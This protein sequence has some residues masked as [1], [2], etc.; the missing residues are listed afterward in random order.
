MIKR[1][2]IAVFESRAVNLT[3]TISSLTYFNPLTKGY[4]PVDS[5]SF[6][7][8]SVNREQSRRP[9]LVNAVG[10]RTRVDYAPH[11]SQRVHL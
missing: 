3:S 4:F 6:V 5:R 10:D 8:S 2:E 1:K 9:A 11:D 7:R